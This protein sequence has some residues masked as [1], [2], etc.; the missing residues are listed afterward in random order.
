[1]RVS[2][3]IYPALAIAVACGFASDTKKTP[4]RPAP[5]ALGI[6]TPGVRIPFA[7]LKSELELEATGHARV[8]RD[9]GFDPD[10]D[11]GRLVADRSRRRK[12][13]SLASRSAGSSSLAAAW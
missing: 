1:M 11:E 13:V 3:G 12:R 2:A 9:G 7:D 6:K 8:D 10:S 5:P 4:K